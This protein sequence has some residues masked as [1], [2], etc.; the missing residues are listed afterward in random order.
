MKIRTLFV[1]FCLFVFIYEV[2]FV[3]IPF[4]TSKQLMEALG[5]IMFFSDGKI[6][7]SLQN[8]F[9]IFLSAA[10]LI[11]IAFFSILVNGGGQWMYHMVLVSVILNF[12]GAFFVCKISRCTIRTFEDLLKAILI[13]VLLQCSITVLF[14]AVPPV[15]DLIYGFVWSEGVADNV[16]YGIESLYRLVGLGNAVAFSVLPTAGLGMLSCGYLLVRSKGKKFFIYS[17][18]LFIIICVSFLVARTSLL[19]AGLSVGYILISLYTNNSKRKLVRFLLLFGGL[20]L[21]VGSVAII[22]LPSDM[23]LWAFEVFLNM[24]DGGSGTDTGTGQLLYSMA[25]ETQFTPMTYL[26]GDAMYT[27][28]SGGYYGGADIGYYRQVYYYGFIGLLA[29]LALHY[30]IIKKSMR[31]CINKESKRFF[32]F[33]FFSFLVILLKGD[34]VIAP[35]FLF[36]LLMMN[37]T[38]APNDSRLPNT[39]ITN[40]LI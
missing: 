24:Q 1:Y 14:K 13:C 2:N 3:F 27:N 22:I 40:K 33:I 6:R 39:D 12:F 11:V 25:T 5:I 19:L 4:L 8:Y 35:L 16:E 21:I 7:G 36:L 37:Y 20:F 26:I 29:F 9:G 34:M 38:I 23:Y 10:L 18:L 28:P 32:L 30:K 15:Y 17:L 31:K